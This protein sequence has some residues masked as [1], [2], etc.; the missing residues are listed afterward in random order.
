MPK[1]PSRADRRREAAA[2]AGCRCS[3]G[4]D[5]GGGLGVEAC[6]SEAMEE[7]HRM[8]PGRRDGVQAAGGGDA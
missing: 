1:A 3:G 4:G 5:D 8:D 6:T 7:E 2:D